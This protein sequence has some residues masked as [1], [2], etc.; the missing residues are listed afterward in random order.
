MR[1][2]L[3]FLHANVLRRARGFLGHRFGWIVF[4]VLLAGCASL[5]ET[6]EGGPPGNGFELVGRVAVRHGDEGTTGRIVWRH[7]PDFDEMLI[8]SV[9]GQG[10]ARITRRHGSVKLVTADHA[11]YQATDAEALTERILGWRLPLTG[12]PEW[13]QGRAAP[14][15]PAMFVRDTQSRISEL[16][17]NGWWIRYQEYQGTRPSRLRMSHNGLEI[18]LIVDKWAG[19][20]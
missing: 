17:Q 16:E 11:E 15:Y 5:P 1:G 2:D 9:L 7:G 8:S 10:I 12:L 6:F 3:T 18:R 14:G 4:S 20:Q 19:S 13:V